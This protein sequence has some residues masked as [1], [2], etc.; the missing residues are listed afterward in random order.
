MSNPRSFHFS[1]DLGTTLVGASG[2]AVGDFF[3]GHFAFDPRQAPTATTPTS[4]TYP[5]LSFTVGVPYARLAPFNLSIQISTD[6]Q[7]PSIKVYGES[8]FGLH[9]GVLFRGPTG[10]LTNT[11]LPTSI[12]LQKFLIENFTISDVKGAL[13]GFDQTGTP[14]PGAKVFLRGKLACINVATGIPTV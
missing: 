3:S 4:A 12:N 5:L 13:F 11:A 1:G 9:V 8:P 10:V 6:P 7:D 14:P 2:I